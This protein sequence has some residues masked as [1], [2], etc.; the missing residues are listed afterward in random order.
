[1]KKEKKKGTKNLWLLNWL[2][3]TVWIASVLTL[4]SRMKKL[5]V[6][7]ECEQAAKGKTQRC[8]GLRAGLSLASAQFVRSRHWLA[9]D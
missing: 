7:K 1:M 9:L 3:L 8:R 6:I 2:Y 4:F 5:W